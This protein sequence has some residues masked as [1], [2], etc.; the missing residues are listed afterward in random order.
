VRLRKYLRKPVWGAV[1]G[2]HLWLAVEG[3][4]RF[5]VPLNRPVSKIFEV[6]KE[7]YKEELSEVARVVEVLKLEEEARRRG[8][9]WEKPPVGRNGP[10]PAPERENAAS[11]GDERG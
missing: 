8:T 2:R 1:R 4:D 11:G 5:S 10:S 7:R 3:K 9:W 6:E